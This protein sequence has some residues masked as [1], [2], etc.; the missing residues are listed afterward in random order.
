MPTGS[1]LDAQLGTKTE[2]TVGTLSTPVTQFF[3]FDSSSLTYDPGYIEGSGLLA[4]IRFKDVSQAAIA[5]K[6]AMGKIEIPVMA[7]GF[8]WWLKHL[9]GSTANPALIASTA[10]KQVHVPGGLRGLSFTAQVGKPE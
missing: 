1:G 9:I 3:P 10:Y 8:G 5:R 7:K 2:T 4:G 6:S